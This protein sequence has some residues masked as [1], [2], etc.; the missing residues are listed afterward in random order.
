MTDAGLR[1]FGIAGFFVSAAVTAHQWAWAAGVVVLYVVANL[2]EK[3]R[4]L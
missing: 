4:E 2:I 3:W 1:K